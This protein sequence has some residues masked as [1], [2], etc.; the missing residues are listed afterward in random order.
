M[1]SGTL[2]AS[3]EL[4]GQGNQPIGLTQLQRCSNLLT[5]GPLGRSHGANEICGGEKERGLYVLFWVDPRAS[6]I[7]LTS[8][9]HFDGYGL[10]VIEIWGIELEIGRGC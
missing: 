1:S 7:R 5:Q 10:I 6:K 4:G 3:G 9:D 2:T 8:L